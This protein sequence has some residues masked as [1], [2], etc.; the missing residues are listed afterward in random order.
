MLDTLTLLVVLIVSNLLMA[1]AM[2]ITFAGRFRAG[3]GPWTG[4]LIVQGFS[5]LLVVSRNDVP[6]FASI[7]V[8]TA[9]LV[10]CWSLQVSALLEFHNKPTPR[11]LLYAPAAIA[12]LI[13][14]IYVREPRARLAICGLGFGLAQFVTGAGLLYYRVSAEKRTRLL[15]AGSFFVMAGGLFWLAFTAWFE[16]EAILPTFGPRPAPGGSLLAFYAVTIASSFAFLLMHKERADRETHELATTDS[17]TGVYNRRTFKELAEPLLSRARRTRGP[18]SLLLLD[19]DHFK[20]VNDTHGHLAGDDVLEG[21][22]RLARTCLRK[23]DLLARYG[24]EEFVVLLP[25]AAETAALA[26]AERIRE[27]VA[28]TPLRAGENEVHITVSIGL[29]GESGEQLPSL[30]GL[31]GRADQALYGAKAQGRNCVVTSAPQ[32]APTA[33]TAAAA[34]A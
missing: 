33:A 9:F 14:V 29:A 22:A 28:N 1:G 12:F 32:P 6:D 30:E 4:S 18:V 13:V 19:L 27:E 11:W 23:E 31:L 24:G 2:W 10:Y 3:L 21:F 16:P 26:L 20:R 15:L 34:S 8:A 7:A 25:G 17:L 5:W